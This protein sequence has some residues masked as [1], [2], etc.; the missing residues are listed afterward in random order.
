MQ[1][2]NATSW[3]MLR[4]QFLCHVLKALFFIKIA[5]KLS[6]ICKKMQNFRALGAQTP[7][8]L[9]RRGLRPQTPQT[10]PHCEFLA[11]RLVPWRIG[12]Q[13]RFLRQPWLHDLGSTCIQVTLFAVL[14]KSRRAARNLPWG[15]LFRKCETTQKW[16]SLEIGTVLCPKLGEDQTKKVFTQAGFDFYNQILFKSKVKV[17]VF[18]LPM[19]MGGGYFCF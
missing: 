6:Y 5:L 3:I 2:I 7:I 17:V 1:P 11:T 10:A 12:M 15:G 13:R 14:V 19:P 4:R 16:F 18:P 9:W 8:G